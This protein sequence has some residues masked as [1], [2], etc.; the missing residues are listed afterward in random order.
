MQQ[1][2]LQQQT[3]YATADV[4][5]ANCLLEISNR[6]VS[7][8]PCV[9]RCAASGRQATIATCTPVLCLGAKQHHMHLQAPGQRLVTPR[10]CNR[11]PREKNQGTKKSSG[12][13]GTTG[14]GDG[15]HSTPQHTIVALPE[16]ACLP[17]CPHKPHPL[18]DL[19][20]FVQSVPPAA[21]RAG[22]CWC[23]TA[24]SAPRG[25]SRGGA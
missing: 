3:L 11:R 16:A 17:P 13:A 10:L 21:S 18:G 4:T 20:Q 6:E 12:G 2:T 7:P 19:G 15:H 5:A 14:S 24:A 23:A 1:Q 25:A 8:V 9:H 22:R